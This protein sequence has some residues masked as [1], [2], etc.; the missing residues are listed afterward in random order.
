MFFEKIQSKIQDLSQSLETVKHW[1]SQGERIVFTNGCFDILHFGHVHYLAE[2]RDLGHRLII[3]I[4]SDASVRKLKGPTRPIQDEQSRLHVLASLAC[5]DAVVLFE[6][7]T[8]YE[9]ISAIHPDIL[10]KGGDWEVSQIVGADL[11]LGEGGEVHSLPFVEG[12]STT[13]IEEKILGN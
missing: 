8:P 1:R 5:V 2:A 4:N 9:L 12:F 10:V 3:G 11:V 6:E 13:K 7:E